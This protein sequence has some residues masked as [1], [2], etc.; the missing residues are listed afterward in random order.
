[1]KR[2]LTGEER[3]IHKQAVSIRKVIAATP[4]RV[5]VEWSK[6]AKAYNTELPQKA[7]GEV[8]MSDLPSTSANFEKFL[9]EIADIGGIGTATVGKL[10]EYAKKNKYL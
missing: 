8:T 7:T 5:L 6:T 4:D 2:R 3:E 10:R 1:M 9:S